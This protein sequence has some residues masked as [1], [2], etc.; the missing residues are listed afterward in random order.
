MV[1]LTLL[2]LAAGAG[3]LSGQATGLA[4]ARGTIDSLAGS[5]AGRVGAAAMVVETGDLVA[6]HGTERFPMQ[7]V[8][9][10]PI[11]MAVLQRIDAGRPTLATVI[12]VRR[13]DLVPAVHSPIRDLNPNGTKLTVRELLRL[14]I[15]ESD[16][17]ASDL[18]LQLFAPPAMVTTMV[19]Q[20]GADSMQVAV[21]ERAMAANPAAQYRSWSSPLAAVRLL[22]ALQSGHG[23]SASSRV[24]LLGW[25]GETSNGEARIRG[26]LPR[27]T[28]VAHK[29]GTDATRAGL[30]RATN[31][32][33]IATLPDGRHLAI[34]VFIRD[35]RATLARREAVIAAIARAAWDAAVR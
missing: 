26:L 35:S 28:A 4:R 1:R 12:N 7:S 8:A 10:V 3:A 31:D 15:V 32:I 20:L 22:A 33:G 2:A 11:A 24:M 5:I 18:L 21:T 27:G 30:T 9:K 23:L 14:A 29:T 16:G 19:H 6:T 13:R 34:A 17:T 25:M